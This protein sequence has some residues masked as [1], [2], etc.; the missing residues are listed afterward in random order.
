MFDSMAK[1]IRVLLLV[2]SFNSVDLREHLREKDTIR[3]E[4][5][6]YRSR[7][8][9]NLLGSLILEIMRSDRQGIRRVF[10]DKIDSKAFILSEIDAR[11]PETVGEVATFSDL[12]SYKF[13]VPVVVKASHA[14]GSV[15][16]VGGSREVRPKLSEIENIWK[17]LFQVQK[18]PMTGSVAHTLLKLVSSRWL[19]Y[20]FTDHGRNEWAYS[21]L[22]KRLIVE[23]FIGD[24]HEIEPPDD[25]KIYFWRCDPFLIHVDSNRFGPRIR[26]YYAP[27]ESLVHISEKYKGN[28]PLPESIHVQEAIR[29]GRELSKR[30]DFV[31][32]DFFVSRDKLFVGELTNYPEGGFGD[33]PPNE[34]LLSLLPAEVRERG[35]RWSKK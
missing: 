18:F 1:L 14:S 6:K 26:N 10:A 19:R 22:R 13:E 24:P 4:R 11:V 9:D 27:D 2:V 29:L 3:F 25:L 23:E 31:R 12:D 15:L 33:L 16:I 8:T 20:R 17:L 21:K 32:V 5:R 28:A 30:V 35:E 7:T 34:V